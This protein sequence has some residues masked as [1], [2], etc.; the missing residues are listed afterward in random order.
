V[1]HDAED[2]SGDPGRKN[3]R[4]TGRDTR[5]RFA[6]GNSG[7]PRGARNRATLSAE[8][9]LDGEAEALTRRAIDLALSG[10]AASLRLCIER[11]LPPRKDR[12]VS[13]ELPPLNGG[14][15][16]AR[17]M[18]ALIA[19]VAEGTITAREAE[20]LTSLVETYRRTL[21]TAELADRVAALEAADGADRS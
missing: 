3:G 6:R 17:A 13:V 8:A 16:A 4:S 11:I 21:E 15:D 2:G 9:L 20:Q 18:G 1:S 10:D 19:A 14:A 7:R 12:T 5:G